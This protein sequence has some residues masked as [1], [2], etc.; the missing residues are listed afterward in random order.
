MST[1]LEEYVPESAEFPKAAGPYRPNQPVPTNDAQRMACLPSDC[2]DD[3][4]QAWKDFVEF[5]RANV[6]FNR[7]KRDYYRKTLSGAFSP[8]GETDLK[9]F[10]KTKGFPLSLPREFSKNPVTLF[11]DGIT[12]IQDE[13]TVSAAFNLSGHSSG[14][15]TLQSGKRVLIPE[16][17]SKK[18][19]APGEPENTLRFLGDLLG[20]EQLFYF[21]AWVKHGLADYR[22]G[23][24]DAWGPHPVLCLVGPPECGKSL[25]QTLITEWIG[26]GYSNPYDMLAG[27]DNGRFTLDLALAA[28]WAI[29]D[30]PGFLN[31]KARAAFTQNLKHHAVGTVLEVH[32]KG[33]DKMQLPT[34]RRLSIS[35]ND[36]ADSLSILPILNQSTRDKLLVLKCFPARDLGH[37]RAGIIRRFRAEH[38][39]FRHYLLNRW[40]VPEDIDDKGSRMRFRLYIHPD[41]ESVM[42]DSNPENRFL[43]LVNLCFFSRGGIDVMAEQRGS[44]S[45]IHSRMTS[46]E[47][48]STA[49]NLVPSAQDCGRMLSNLCASMPERFS[50]KNHSGSMA[51]TIRPPGV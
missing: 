32:G 43:E 15:F 30:K 22:S 10:L 14:M 20:E 16:G 40:Q 31:S 17:V 41:V 44:A 12:F 13:L 51:Y 42:L 46:G 8:V 27:N 28:H 23:N 4:R 38:A 49:R 7:E 25:A 19:I 45:E 5:L 21:L 26:G 3:Y 9:R 29:E 48:S 1:L 24:P 37:D 39:A 6:V 34:F 33:R 36:D 50:R 18:D 2:P 47:H 11:D 35:C